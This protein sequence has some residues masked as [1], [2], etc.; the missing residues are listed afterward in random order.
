M[1]R[2]H[3]QFL[4]DCKARHRSCS[5]REP[6]RCH[7]HLHSFLLRTEA[8]STS[9]RPIQPT[10]IPSWADEV[11][12]AKQSGHST[13]ETVVPNWANSGRIRGARPRSQPLVYPPP[14][15]PTPHTQRP[16]VPSPRYCPA[17]PPLRP[18]Q[19][20]PQPPP[21]DRPTSTDN[22]PCTDPS[23]R[24]RPRATAHEIYPARSSPIQASQS[25]ARHTASPSRGPQP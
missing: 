19:S 16:R 12:T 18:H 8:V 2:A 25:P 6:A 1:T 11:A 23:P 7:R 17:I 14:V 4:Q 22:Y 13:P 3:P 10:S 20:F 21:Y 24:R 9:Q 5:S 15:M